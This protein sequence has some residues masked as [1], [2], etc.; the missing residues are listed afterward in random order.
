M[1]MIKESYLLIA[2]T[3]DVLAAP[4]RLSAIPRNGWLSLELSATHCDSTNNATVT[5]QLPDGSIPLE[6]VHIPY[7][8]AGS[9]EST[10]DSRTALQMQFGVAGGGHVLLAI[11]E[12]G[13]VAGVLIFATLTF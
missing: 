12:A 4:S 11:T 13:T 3:A 1:P 5:L 7:D 8:G 2:S 6:G 10:I 9:T